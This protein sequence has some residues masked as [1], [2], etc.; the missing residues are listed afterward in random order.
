MKGK[1]DKAIDKILKG[2]KPVA[3]IPYCSVIKV[4]LEYLAATGQL[5]NNGNGIYICRINKTNG[6]FTCYEM[7][8]SLN[9]A[10]FDVIITSKT[11]SNSGAETSPYIDL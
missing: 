8:K 4:L 2:K 9:D 5:Q 6:N 10:P 1:S 3:E 11:T 7:P